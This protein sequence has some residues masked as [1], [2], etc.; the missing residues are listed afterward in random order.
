M[1]ELEVVDKNG[2]RYTLIDKD[3]K[4][5]DLNIEVM[6]TGYDI[7]IGDIMYI[8][9]EVVNKERMLTFGKIGSEYGVSMNDINDKEIV[10]FMRDNIK[11]YFKRIYG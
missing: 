5:Y 7:M 6:D 11:Y 4:K 3:D 8:S 9:T 1:I 10:V 2:Y